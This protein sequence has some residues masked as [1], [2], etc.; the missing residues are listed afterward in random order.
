MLNKSIFPI[1]GV[2]SGRKRS[3]CKAGF[4]II[5]CL[6]LLNIFCLFSLLTKIY[7]TIHLTHPL[8]NLLQITYHNSLMMFFWKPNGQ[9]ITIQTSHSTPP[10]LSISGMKYLGTCR[11]LIDPRGLLVF[12][13]R[14][15]GGLLPHSGLKGEWG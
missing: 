15:N 1:G 9:G 3:G 6:S 14:L 13:A 11:S 10:T 5:S 8:L 7:R 2:A 12:A 4:V